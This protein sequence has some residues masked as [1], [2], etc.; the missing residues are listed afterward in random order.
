MIEKQFL[1]PDVEYSQ[2]VFKKLFQV[3]E[4]NQALGVDKKESG[5]QNYTLQWTE[6]VY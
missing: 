3:Y 4:H 1:A 2:G 6:V 5:K